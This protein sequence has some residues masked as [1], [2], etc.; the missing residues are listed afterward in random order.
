MK[1]DRSYLRITAKCCFPFAF[2][3]KYISIRDDTGEEIGI[4]PDLAHLDKKT[5]RWIEDELELRYFT[6]RVKSID[7]VRY[8]YGG[9]EWH[10]ETDRG[11]KKIITKGVHDTMCE[12]EPQRYL[13]TDVD[14]NRYEV[15]VDKLDQAS[16]ALLDKL[17]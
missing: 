7:N 15:F 11:F 14:G 2:P 5:R 3:T 17:I 16:R 13:I 6:P 12:V 1:N 8:R 9:V 4:I 10:L